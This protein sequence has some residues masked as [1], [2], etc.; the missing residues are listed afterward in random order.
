MKNLDSFFEK[1]KSFGKHAILVG[2]S[3]FLLASGCGGD[4]KPTTPEPEPPKEELNLTSDTHV[5]NPTTASKILSY[6]QTTGALVFEEQTPQTDSLKVGS[7]INYGHGNKLPKG[8]L[9][10]IKTIS[11]DKKTFYTEST[12]LEECIDGEFELTIK[13][14][15]Q[16]YLYSFEGENFLKPLSPENP[17]FDFNI[18]LD[19]TFRD[20]DGDFNTKD[21]QTWVEGNFNFNSQLKIKFIKEGPGLVVEEQANESVKIDFHSNISASFTEEI[22]VVEIPL[23]TITIPIPTPI[24]FYLVITSDILGFVGAEGNF[25]GGLETNVTQTSS[26]IAGFKYE[27][28]WSKY[29]TFNNSFPDFTVNAFANAYFEIYGKV[30]IESELYS[31]A[32]PYAYLTC[33]SKLDA[34]ASRDPLWKLSAGFEVTGGA[35]VE[36]FSLKIA[37]L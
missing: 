33:F 17:Q 30:G 37:R 22:K 32:G 23:P 24:P 13:R 14:T 7:R 3:S 1:G 18:P 12:S 16:G 10:K 28:G 34:D 6:D 2:L 19:Y 29:H 21:D 25:S 15:P 8:I 20:I 5:L 11:P 4:K 26:L 35:K 36:I 27:K 9:A 31:S